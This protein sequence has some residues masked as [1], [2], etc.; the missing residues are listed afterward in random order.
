M[1]QVLLTALWLLCLCDKKEGGGRVCF[2][3]SKMLVLLFDG[4]LEFVGFFACLVLVVYCLYLLALSRVL[5]FMF[6]LVLLLAVVCFS[7]FCPQLLFCFT[8]SLIYFT[9]AFVVVVVV[10]SL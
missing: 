2:A 3:K 7:S 10:V 8:F 1:H 4:I 9:V 6:F 5:A